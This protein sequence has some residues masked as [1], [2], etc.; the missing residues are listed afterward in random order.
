MIPHILRVPSNR[1]YVD[2]IE[3]EELLQHGPIVAGYL[4][5]WW[6]ASCYCEARDLKF[7]QR[8]GDEND[9]KA[10]AEWKRGY[11]YRKMVRTLQR[12][13]RERKNKEKEKAKKAKKI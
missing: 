12:R 3:E 8:G 4:T 10:W 2:A 5:R 9:E 13:R 6:R 11:K 1:E 7:R